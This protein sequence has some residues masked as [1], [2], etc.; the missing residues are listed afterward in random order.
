MALTAAQVRTVLYRLP[1]ADGTISIYDAGHVCWAY[2]WGVPTVDFAGQADIAFSSGMVGHLKAALAGQ[3]DIAFDA[4]A[5]MSRI[6]FFARDDIADLL[7]RWPLDIYNASGTDIYDTKYGNDGVS[8]NTPVFDVGPYGRANRAMTFNGVDDWINCGTDNSLDFGTGAFSISVWINPL[9]NTTTN[10]GVLTKGIGDWS[11]S[12]GAKTGWHFGSVLTNAWRFTISDGDVGVRGD[13]LNFGSLDNDGWLH[14]GVTVDDAGDVS[15]MIRGYKN[16]IVVENIARSNALGSIDV[17]NNLYIGATY[18]GDIAGVQIYNRALSAPEVAQLFTP[19]QADISFSASA[20]AARTRGI[21]GQAD[22][23]ISA[24]V[25]AHMKAALA[26]QADIAFSTAII[27]Q[28]NRDFAGQADIIFSASAEGTRII[29]LSGQTDIVF[30]AAS[31][32]NRLRGLS[33]QADIA[34]NADIIAEINRFLSGQSNISFNAETVAQLNRFLSG[35]ADIAFST[36]L[37]ASFNI[38]LG[39]QADIEFT[40]FLTAGID[41]DT[42]MVVGY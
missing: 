40:T 27:P 15:P 18:N 9:T 29:A 10:T 12:A 4:S 32:A 20:A 11:T 21:S 34:F 33:G 6:R 31:I 3:A 25:V 17:A 5:E 22:I 13:M 36:S 1:D 7:S 24:A 37:A 14:I 30:S 42:G 39:G 41:G 28:L 2:T 8:A 19:D 16:G 35:Q 38:Q 23:A 26:G